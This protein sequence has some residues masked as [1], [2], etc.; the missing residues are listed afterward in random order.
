MTRSMRTLMVVTCVLFVFPL[1]KAQGQSSARGTVVVPDS[2][3]EHP[4]DQG[5]RAH[6]NFVIFVPGAKSAGRSQPQA[7]AAPSG[8]TPASL[9]CVYKTWAG[10]GGVTG[11]PIN[12]GSYHA[13]S[14]GTNVIAIVDA[15]DYPTAAID[16]QVFSTQFKLPYGNV[17]GSDGKQPCLTVE[18]ATG[19]KPRSNCGWA[20]EAA[21]DIEWAHAMAPYAQIILVEAASNSNTNLMQAVQVARDAVAGAGGGEVSMSWGS[22]EF[23]T[24]STYD[25]YFSG[26][27][28]AY[29][30]SSGDS[31]GKVIWP[32]AS[33]NVLSAGGTSVNRSNGNF[34]YESAWSSAGG[35]PSK[36]EPIPGYQSGIYSL[37]QLLGNYRGTPDLSF[38][39]DPYTGVSV[40]DSTACQGY[41]NWMVFGGTSVSSPSLAGVANYSGNFSGD[42]GVQNAL[43][44]NY[45]SVSSGGASSPY[46]GDFYDVTSGSAGSYPAGNDWDFASGIG[47]VR[48]VAGFG[49]GSA[50]PDF[51]MSSSPSSL[52][53]TQ[54]QT[55]TSTIT[56]S[57][58]DGFSSA[59]KLG[60]SGCPASPSNVCGLSSSSITGG[61]GFVTLTVT[62]DSTTA[63]GTHTI[64]V[65][66][67]SG[68]LSHSASVALTV[69]APASGDFSIS[70]SPGNVV[71]KGAS[72]ASYTVAIS[73][74]NGYASDV[75]VSV[76]NLPPSS[77][78]TSAVVSGGSGSATVSV[79]TTGSTPK[80][81]YTLTITG[82]G[83]GGTP[84]H[85]TTV[86]LKVH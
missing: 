84:V 82:T 48:G 79:T 5:V 56:V 71:L 6:T 25:S 68:S 18:Y 74:S 9:S 33:A 59:V 52:T 13:P 7:N 45:S 10:D 30:A 43:Y 80:G 76:G 83:S 72:T 21:L 58:Q 57:P 55:G 53:L 1:L 34:T 16:F 78:A 24:E 29:F 41:V 46:T 38:D 31:G 54:G 67:T 50:S 75:S 63:T 32:S 62:T 77:S 69:N 3:V 36:Y 81:N 40:Y 15:Y 27:G 42:D 8:E 14:G 61:S 28:V 12:G 37:S 85:S 35:G 70:A 65:T 60:V 11:C 39:A 4:G 49:G 51:S 26:S 64:V 22:S 19:S 17:C 47:T 23:S 73:P 2:S 44:Q 86:G 20:Q 66:G